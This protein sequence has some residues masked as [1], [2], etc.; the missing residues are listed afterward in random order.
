[1][2][3]LDAASQTFYSLGIAYGSLIAFASY[4]P[5]KNDTTRDAVTICLI[6]AGVSIYA[7]VVIFCFIGYRA[8]IKMYNCL[9]STMDQY[10]TLSHLHP[11][12][13]NPLIKNMTNV[14]AC[15]KNVFLSEVSHKFL[16]LLLQYPLNL[17]VL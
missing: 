1:M 5:L 4:N 17:N 13:I 9:N 2:V 10:D 6:D 14:T 15:D 11:I 3:W 7:S 8:Q 12:I 16:F